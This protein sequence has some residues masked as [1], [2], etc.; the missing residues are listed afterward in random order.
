MYKSRTFRILACQLLL[1]LSWTLAHN[2][3]TDLERYSIPPGNWASGNWARLGYVQHHR[4]H[5]IIPVTVF[6]F[7]GFPFKQV[8]ICS[9]YSTIS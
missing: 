6:F 5:L 1:K 7:T 2:Q 3:N 9:R 4:S 8:I